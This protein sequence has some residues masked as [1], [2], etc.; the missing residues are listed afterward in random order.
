MIKY[1]LI[2][3]ILAY[4]IPTIG[5]MVYGLN[6]YVMLAL[7]QRRRKVAADARKKILLEVG[8]L[9]ARQDIPFV[10]TQIAIFNEHNVA[11][12]VIRAV[13]AMR[14]PRNKH[15]IQV[16]D[17]STDDTRVVVDRAVAEM[18]A[19]GYDIHVLHRQ[20][21]TGYKGGALAAG[22]QVAR[23]ELVAVFDADFVPPE[24]YLVS[25]V[26][27][28]MRDSKIGFVQARWGH[29]NKH[30]SLLT[31]AQSL[32]ID[33]HFIIEQIARGWNSLF[34][35]FNGTA[36]TWRKEAILSGGGWQ[37]DTLTEDLDLSYRVQFAGWKAL[38]L[39]D[40]VVPAELPETISAFRSQQFRWAKGSF[41]TLLKLFPRLRDEQCPFFKK[42]EAVLHIAGYGV[43]PLMLWLS[44]LALPLLFL[45]HYLSPPTWFFAVFTLPLAL[46]MVGPSLLYVLA[47]C[48]VDR[49]HG[50]KS[51]FLMPALM[52][53]GTGLA[54][55]NTRAI[56]EAVRGHQSEF[57]RTPKRG[58][59]EV[60]RYAQQ[61]PLVAFIEIA[62]G[63]YSLYTVY[64]YFHHARYGMAPFLLIY[65]CG[66]LYIG[67]L[68]VFQSLRLHA[69]RA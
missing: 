14:Y 36:G 27:F 3:L 7:F 46:S 5:L 12:R 48:V 62:L 16:L 50:W 59:K 26:P 68:S 20:L 57:V 32:G 31:R 4:L 53:V 34:M 6:C 61:F 47:Q 63:I 37:W 60:K 23:G 41:Q 9:L 10:T 2:A 67:I 15:E 24:D 54:F 19:Q 40:L 29:L 22:L 25:M 42:V 17:D 21:R 8:D 44:V 30:T 56:L 66:Y 33:G 39:P 43:H 51:L 69:S 55:S 65:A 18:R 64:V 49:R 52:V 28:F 1:L 38:Y 11:D 45:S 13:C 35:N 58:D